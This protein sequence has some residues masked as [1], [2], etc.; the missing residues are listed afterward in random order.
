VKKL[1]VL[2]SL[3]ATNFMLTNNAQAIECIPIDP[4]EPGEGCVEIIDITTD[5]DPFGAYNLNFR[6]FANPSD[7]HVTLSYVIDPTLYN[8]VDITASMAGS[9]TDGSSTRDGVSITPIDSK[10]VVTYALTGA[11]SS[12]PLNFGLGDAQS[13]SA[14]PPDSH[15]YGPFDQ[16]GVPAADLVYDCGSLSSGCT[17][18]DIIFK[19]TGSGGGDRF[20]FTG[21]LDILPQLVPSTILGP[22]TL[23]SVPLV[24]SIN[25]EPVK[26]FNLVPLK[27]NNQIFQLETVPEPSSSIFLIG[28]GL[29]LVNKKFQTIVNKPE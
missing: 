26:T 29:Y 24:L 28:L 12:I 22:T 4:N 21:R 16:T 11:S 2:G 9:L 8:P 20:G 23:P 7:F 3:V 19:F 10:G 6:D 18:F 17:G 5:P 13:S 1:L 15:T 27:T 14:G 25:D